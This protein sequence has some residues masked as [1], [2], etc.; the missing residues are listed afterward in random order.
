MLSRVTPRGVPIDIFS[1]Q[2]HIKLHGRHDQVNWRCLTVAP[3]HCAG[4]RERAIHMCMYLVGI[5]HLANVQT[6]LSPGISDHQKGCHLFFIIFWRQLQTKNNVQKEQQTSSKH[7]QPPHPPCLPLPL[8][9]QIRTKQT[10]PTAQSVTWLNIDDVTAGIAKPI[11]LFS[12]DYTQEEGS[13]DGIVACQS[14]RC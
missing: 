7:H 3:P 6:S 13:H 12:K 14:I 10:P 1:D 9:P 2:I 8:R 11:L 4:V 5:S